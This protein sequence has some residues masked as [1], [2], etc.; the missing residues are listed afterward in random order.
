MKNRKASHWWFHQLHSL[1]RGRFGAPK[2][3]PS[4][5]RALRMEEDYGLQ[6]TLPMRSPARF[7]LGN[8]STVGSISRLLCTRDILHSPATV[9]IKARNLTLRGISANR[10][11]FCLEQSHKNG[12]I[13]SHREEAYVIV[14]HTGDCGEVSVGGDCNNRAGK[15]ANP[16]F[17]KLEIRLENMSWHDSQDLQSADEVRQVLVGRSSSRDGRNSTASLAL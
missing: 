10:T 7:A 13:I 3:T 14:S 5:Q 6:C 1:D 8:L 16:A 2:N 17:E 15:P 9:D 11:C 12:A 4:M